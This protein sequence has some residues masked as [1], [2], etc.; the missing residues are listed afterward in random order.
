M[1]YSIISTSSNHAAFVPYRVQVNMK[2]VLEYRINIRK[3]VSKS[4]YYRLDFCCFVF[5]FLSKNEYYYQTA[6]G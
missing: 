3:T 5:F 2:Y 4:I 6:S 1:F